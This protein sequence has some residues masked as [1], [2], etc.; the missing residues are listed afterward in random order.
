[1]LS[2]DEFQVHCKL[3]GLSSEAQA[4]IIRI[5]STQ[6]FQRIRSG[7]NRVACFFPSR[8]MGRTIQA[9]NQS[10]HLAAIYLYEYDKDVLEFWDE[11][12]QIKVTTP[13]RS[14]GRLGAFMAK[15]PY[16]VIHQNY[17]GWEEW[18]SEN[19]LEH[20]AAEHPH[21]YRIDDKRIWHYL[22]GEEY[23]TKLGLIYHIRTDS[24]LGDTLIRNLHFLGDYLQ[25]EDDN[26][27]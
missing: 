3:L 2:P 26:V 23:A 16:F 5:R 17:A 13:A 6:P 24:E 20:Q 7:A 11:P 19:W 18:K 15:P 27:I 1:M 10:L 22:P 12:G 9:A 14:D 21:L 25:Q 8:K 4:L